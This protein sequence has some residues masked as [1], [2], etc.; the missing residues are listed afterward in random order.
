M[1]S[2]LPVYN[3]TLVEGAD[4]ALSL[5][6]QEDGVPINLTDYTFEA[7]IKEDFSDSAMTLAAFT[8][9]KPNPATGEVV[10]S[11]TS[12]VTQGMFTASDATRS[13]GYVGYWDVFFTNAVGTRQYL[14]GGRVTFIQTITARVV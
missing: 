3:I 1:S 6:L 14:L 9:T 13:R 8:A 2:S 7:S 12:T 4:Y 10:L 11:M 5:I